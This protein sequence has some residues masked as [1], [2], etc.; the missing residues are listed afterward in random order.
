MTPPSLAARSSG[1]GSLRDA[2]ATYVAHRESPVCEHCRSP[3]SDASRRSG[4][5]Y[6]CAGCESVH[7]F[8]VGNAFD[9]YYARLAAVDATAPSQDSGNA[10]AAGRANGRANAPADLSSFDEPVI[11]ERLAS[12]EGSFT[13]F[14]P[15]L[16][17]AA[18]LWLVEKA[19]GDVAGVE[20]ARVDLLDKRVRVRLASGASL[21]AVACRL[22]ELGYEPYPPALSGQGA[23]ADAWERAR[24][25]DLGL[26]CILFANVMTFAAASYLGASRGMPPEWANAFRWLSLAL[27][28]PCLAGPGRVYFV[29]AWRSLRARALH[30]DLPIAAALAFALGVSVHSLAVGGD[31]VYFDSITGLVFLLGAGRYFNERLVR[32]ARDLT[33]ASASLLPERSRLLSPGD[34]VDVALGEIIPADGTLLEGRTEV[35]ESA[36]TGESHPVAKEPGDA[37]L[38]GTVNLGRPVTLRVDK[39]RADAFVARFERLATETLAGRSRA[40]GIAERTLPLFVSIVCIVALVAGAWWAYADPTRVV[41]VVLAIF[42]VGCPCGLALA[43]PLASSVALARAWREGVIVKSA[44]VLERLSDIDTIVVDKTGTLTR[45]EPAV[46]SSLELGVPAAFRARVASLARRSRHPSARAVAAYEDVRRRENASA[47]QDIDAVL[48]D[49]EEIPGRGLRA[50]FD[51]SQGILHLGSLGALSADGTLDAVQV[52]RCERFLALRPVASGLVATD[53]ARLVMYAL[54]DEPRPEAAVSV[55]RWQAAGYEV[56]LASGDAQGPSASIGARIGLTNAAVHAAMTPEDKRLLVERLTEAGRKVLV[57]GDGV[58]DAT[59]MARAHVALAVRGGV[60]LALSTADACLWKEG[61]EGVAPLLAFSRRARG[62]LATVLGTSAAYNAIALSI[63][64]T[65]A[66]HPLVA[67]LIMPAASV[68]ALAVAW[69]RDG[70]H[71]WARS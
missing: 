58:N 25:R 6:C 32:K 7:A 1:G 37:L 61:L 38:A 18:C 14:V 22:R 19:V 45:G 42:I 64:V 8:L 4:A 53:G 68:T 24:R 15:S 46:V 35:D 3:I 57:V 71:P 69:A 27:T 23:F 60:D 52:A 16:R 65:G 40:D 44:A 26:S 34:R 41:P 31:D 39:A 54:E 5:R 2:L 11:R 56:V 33:A 47:H 48:T 9:D 67:A 55:A 12:R 63:A 36:L 30:Y 13:F 20:E 70:G 59:A 51:G 28:V 66:L 29:N 50:R 21:A 17:C 62:T 10:G 43:A 49:V